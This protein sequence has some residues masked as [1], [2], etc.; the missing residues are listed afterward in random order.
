MGTWIT[1]CV[2]ICVHVCVVLLCDCMWLCVSLLCVAVHSSSCS[3]V[4][5]CQQS[6]GH[7][8]SWCILCAALN[9]LHPTPYDLQVVVFPYLT[10]LDRIVD[11]L[12]A[13]AV[14]A[15][16][17]GSLLHL[18]PEAVEEVRWQAHAAHVGRAPWT[19]CSANPLQPILPHPPLLPSTLQCACG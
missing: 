10:N 4:G 6:S 11:D 5:A 15:L 12:G 3:C 1:L 19:T 9:T 7:T 18:L 8:P 13:L 16:F 14:G 2:H 17:G